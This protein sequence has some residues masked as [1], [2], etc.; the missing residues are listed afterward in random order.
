MSQVLIADDEEALLDILAEAVRR[1]GHEVVVALDGEEA[2]ALIRARPPDVVLTDLMMPR[3]S[4]AELIAALR[5]DTALTKLPVVLMSALRAG[6]FGADRCLVKPVT[7]EQLEATLADVLAG[8]SAPA[9][10]GDTPDR[11]PISDIRH[12]GERL[13]P[14]IAHELKTPLSAARL[15]TDLLL[16]PDSGLEAKALT[17]V[18]LIARQLERMTELVNDALEAG[19]LAEGRVSLDR[20]VSDLAAWIALVVDEWRALE[21]SFTFEL[22]RP[23]GPVQVPF[24]APRLRIVLDN[25]LSNACKYGLPS[26]VIEV[27]LSVSPALATICVTDHGPG[28]AASEQRRIFDQFQQAG[29]DQR[30][31]GHG[32]GLFIAERLTRLHRGSLRVRSELGEGATFCVSLPRV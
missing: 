22:E 11:F 16:R 20:Q 14:W 10:S 5:A 30:K 26:K 6:S 3:R 8:R 13:L 19:Q 29:P 31:K 12:V 9:R 4:G 2:L 25:L 15:S 17:R 24:D 28:I 27:G 1:M 32:L 7:I 23:E 18:R 21:P